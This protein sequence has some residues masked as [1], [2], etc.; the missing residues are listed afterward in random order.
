MGLTAN[1]HNGFL[2]EL[3]SA[4]FAVLRSN[5]VSFDTRPGQVLH[6]WGDPVH[7]V[8]FPQA[9]L[10]IMTVPLVNSVA[11]GLIGREGVVGGLAATAATSATCNAEVAIGGRAVRTSALEFRYVLENNEGIRRL[12]GRYDAAMVAQVQQIAACNAAHQVDSRVCR[13]LLEIH[14]RIGTSTIPLIQNALA[15][16]L[17]VRRT[18]VT[19]VAG[20]LEKTGILHCHR[21][22]I[23]IIDR[24]GLERRSCECY[25]RTKNYINQLCVAPHDARWSP[26][27]PSGRSC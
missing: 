10:V 24:G 5:L 18:T 6:N 13:W 3:S 7:D 25:K 27:T 26:A 2:S 14:D 15:E 19:L 21:G 20:R 12:A 4:E 1:D 23:Q 8:I 17:S 22:Y 16:M 9:G 11:V